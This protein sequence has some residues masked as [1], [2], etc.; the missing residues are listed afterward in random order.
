MRKDSQWKKLKNHTMEPRPCSSARKDCQ[1][2]CPGR[3]CL[4]V[5]SQEAAD[6]SLF[7]SHPVSKNQLKKKKA[8]R[9][10]PSSLLKSHTVGKR[11][12]KPSKGKS[13]RPE[14]ACICKK[15]SLSGALGLSHLASGRWGPG[16]WG[17]SCLL[18]PARA[19]L[20]STVTV[21]KA[22]STCVCVCVRGEGEDG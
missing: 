20:L 18:R 1:A 8:L 19:R 6:I 13:K 2:Q 12:Q 17:I 7:L 5:P 3:G 4:Q 14:L 21:Q 9:K 11:T 22:S 16:P 10:D 15:L